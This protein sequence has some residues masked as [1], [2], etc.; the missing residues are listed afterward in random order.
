MGLNGVRNDLSRRRP[1]GAQQ[2][3]SFF[4]RLTKNPLRLAALD[5]SPIGMGE[6]GASNEMLQLGETCS[7]KRATPRAPSSPASG[8]SAPKGRW[9]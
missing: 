5:T 8:G 7:E 2:Y 1:D 6:E 9:G 3:P 4:L